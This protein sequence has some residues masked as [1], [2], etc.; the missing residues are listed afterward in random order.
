M[1]HNVGLFS[2]QIALGVNRPQNT[3]K[4]QRTILMIL[5]FYKINFP[6]KKT[7]DKQG[8]QCFKYKTT[9]I[10][11]HNV[12]QSVVSMLPPRQEMIPEFNIYLFVEHNRESVLCGFHSDDVYS[13]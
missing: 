1:T 5:F 9:V 7:N 13:Q 2:S 4:K 12:C 6:A 3:A 11:I 8:T 10:N